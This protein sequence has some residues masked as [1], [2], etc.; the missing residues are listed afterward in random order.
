MRRSVIR[1]TIMRPY[2]LD[3]LQYECVY[4]FLF[5]QV[6][7]L[8][9]SVSFFFC[10]QWTCCMLWV[11]TTTNT[12]IDRRYV[13]TRTECL[14]CV[15]ACVALRL[16]AWLTYTK[17]HISWFR[18]IYLRRQLFWMK[19]E[20]MRS[21]LWTWNSIKNS[22]LFS[23]IWLYYYSVSLFYSTEEHFILRRNSN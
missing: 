20:W 5:V 19:S 13:C 22:S 3:E 21:K 8:P 7:H 23:F 16:V 6:I 14:A 2:S 10:S 9:V 11:T 18:P 4:S 12:T 17:T 15:F 1:Y